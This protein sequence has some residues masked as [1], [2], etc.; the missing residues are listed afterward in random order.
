MTGTGPL[1]GTSATTGSGAEVVG[2]ALIGAGST[3]V[4]TAGAGAG[5]A[6][7]R[8]S[9]SVGTGGIGAPGWVA[10]P[11]LVSSCSFALAGLIGVGTIAGAATAS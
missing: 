1:N 8:G 3:T 9:L 4:S 5:A 7:T 2:A 11:P 10:A 6:S